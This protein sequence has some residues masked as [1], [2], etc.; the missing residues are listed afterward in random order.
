VLR[1]GWDGTDLSVLTVKPVSA[2]EPH[3][4][5]IGHVTKEELLRQLTATS[6]ANGFLNRFLL[7][8]VQR[9]QLLPHGSPIP[10]G[11]WRE[12]RTQVRA[13]V[14]R[15]R[16]LAAMGR[17]PAADARWADVYA[18]LSKGRPG[19]VGAILGRAEAHVLRLSTLYA[20]LEGQETVDVVHLEAAL[21]LWAYVEGSVQWVFGRK[22]GHALADQL[23]D[24]LRAMGPDGLSRTEMGKEFD[25]HQSKRDLDVALRLLQEAGL[26]RPTRLPTGGRPEERW[27]TTEAGC[28]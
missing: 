4:S 1:Q 15:A 24:R 3:L 22:L 28:P 20:A 13:A 18:E 16:S 17:S 21:A 27:V 14:D 6:M 26:A 10:E 11:A 7:V 23:D 19:W 5:I 9:A 2:T 8:A 12:V 25:G